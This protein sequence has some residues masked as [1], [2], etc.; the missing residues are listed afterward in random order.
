ML[1]VN[2]FTKKLASALF[3][4]LSP[5]WA[6]SAAEKTEDDNKTDPSSGLEWK[7]DAGL[8]YDSNIYRAPGA[9]YI[10][11]ADSCTL[12]DANCVDS[13]DNV[14]GNNLGYVK[15]SPQIKSG[16]FIP[17]ELKVDYLKNLA[18]NNIFLASYTASGDFYAQSQYNNANNYGNKLHAG[19]QWIFSTQHNQQHSFYVGG[20]LEYKKR[21]YLDRDTG[22]DQETA[23]HVDISGRYTY[24]AYGLESVLEGKVNGFQY[25]IDATIAKR[26]YEDPVVVSQYDHTYY[27]LGGKTKFRLAK[28]TKLSVGYDYYIY[29]Y[30]ERPSRSL[31]DGRL[32]VS[33]PPR[34]YQYNKI[35]VSLRQRLSKAWLVY[36]DYEHRT[37]TDKYQGYDNY[38][39]NLFKTRLHYVINKSNRLKFSYTY[40]KRDYPNAFAYDNADY[41]ATAAVVNISKK[42]DGSEAKLSW[43]NALDRHKA[44][45]FEVDYYKENSSDLRYDF[46]RYRTLVSFEWE[47]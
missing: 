26:N 23:A 28:F 44:I 15:V 35:N 24:D 18:T 7:L 43:T 20:L 22:E 12:A 40:W 27:S 38:T 2:S 14:T 16:V 37:R 9:P 1:Y 19:D 17:L 45:V 4:G 8:G 29:D 3:V 6:V 39:K 46:E 34:K 42:Y 25:A 32:L 30:V 5:Y 31:I 36:L 33:N 11:Y 13:A 41:D 47:Y 10:N 21:L